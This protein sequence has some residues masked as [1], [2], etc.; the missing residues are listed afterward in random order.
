MEI[1]SK[2]CRL[3]YA[4]AVVVTVHF[5]IAIWHGVT[6]MHVPVALSG[7]QIFFPSLLC[8]CFRLLLQLFSGAGGD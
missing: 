7:G 6:H 4:L 2:T 5:F 3:D 8:S 1:V